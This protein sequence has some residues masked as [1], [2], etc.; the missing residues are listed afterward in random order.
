MAGVKR[1]PTLNDLREELA[2]AR[3]AYELCSFIDHYPDVVRCRDREQQKIDTLK[4]KIV[5]CEETVR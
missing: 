5:E 1:F 3:Q 4:A 2:E